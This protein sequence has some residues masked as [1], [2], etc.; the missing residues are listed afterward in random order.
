M[1]V[2]VIDTGWG[3]L[4]ALKQF[5]VKLGY[6]VKVL[7]VGELKA[8]KPVNYICVIPGVGSA[9]RFAKF[10]TSDLNL[11]LSFIKKAK[12]TIGICLGAHFMT[13]ST[14]EADVKG[15]NFVNCKVQ[16]IKD[17]FEI[18]YRK[19]KYGSSYYSIYHCHSY[20]IPRHS[21]TISVGELAN[22]T[23]YS[24]IIRTNNSCLIQGHPEKSGLDG[25]LLIKSILEEV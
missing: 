11:L 20:Y 24:Q 1:D 13:S 15:L 9:S 21:S 7:G 8:S 3:N 19:V 4:L 10:S 14:E 25:E 16:K 2:V 23:E 17:G 5:F 22:K 12:F 6:T 18:G